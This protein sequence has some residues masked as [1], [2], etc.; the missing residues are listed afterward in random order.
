MERLSSAQ[1]GFGAG[2]QPTEGLRGHSPVPEDIYL[3]LGGTAGGLKIEEQLVCCLLVLQRI[4]QLA[5]GHKGGGRPSVGASFL[6]GQEQL[7]V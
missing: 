2:A 1:S 4:R 7:E 5:A 6:T 3:S